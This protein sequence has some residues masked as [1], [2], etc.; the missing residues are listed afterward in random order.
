MPCPIPRSTSAALLAGLVLTLAVGQSPS[1]AG[2]AQDPE[3][4][5][6]CASSTTVEVRVGAQY[7]ICRAWF[8]TDLGEGADGAVV[9]GL[10]TV[11]EVGASFAP[12]RAPAHV[13]V[14]WQRDGCAEGWLYV[15]EVPSGPSLTLSRRCPGEAR[16]QVDLDPGAV[17]VDGSRIT[18]RLAVDDFSRTG[19]AL[20]AGA[21]LAQPRASVA[22]TVKPSGPLGGEATVG[23]TTAGPG[24]AYVVGSDGS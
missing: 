19:A 15:D 6:D 11:V 16:R 14:G 9:Q 23:G 12:P 8:Q 2:T 22:P 17:T 18:V 7:E 24:R 3:V 10:R 13:G 20:A 1:A 21:V 4:E 5:G